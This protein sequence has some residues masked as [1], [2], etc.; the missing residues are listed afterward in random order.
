MNNE[1]TA[2]PRTADVQL[3]TGV[4][5]N[6][7][8]GGDVGGRPVVL[9]HGYTDSWFSYSRVLPLLAPEYRAYAP[10]QRGHGDSERPVGGY[11]MA[12]FAADVIAF[13][14]ALGL[15]QATVVGHSMGSLVAMETALAAPERVERLVLIGSATDMRSEDMLGLRREVDAL[16]D[17]VPEEFAR[18][19][20]VSTIHHPIPEEFLERAV[21][22]SLKLPARVWR[23]ALAGQLAADYAPGLAG[24]RMPALLLRGDRDALF[25]R[26][27]QEALPAGLPQAVSKIYAD[28]G[29]AL[30]WERP[31]EFVRD[32]EEFMARAE[33]PRHAAFAS[34]ARE[35]ADLRAR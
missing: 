31:A 9:L 22:E 26:A 8:E 15:P 10:S 13:M 21:A 3:S 16:E 29:H 4:R 20:Q 24:I 27:S 35:K 14:D 28:T 1:N 6:Y 34:P 23:D 17:P 33:P 25:P 2:P 18:E 5:L 11:A 30:H 19:F 32:F 12:D 7:A